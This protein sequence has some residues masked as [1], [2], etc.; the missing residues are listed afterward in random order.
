MELENLLKKLFEKIIE[1]YNLGISI[2]SE[3]EVVLFCDK[4]ILSFLLHSAELEMV[5]I[6]KRE[7]EELYQY[8]ID[9]FITYSISDED[10]LR[11][12]SFLIN[13]SKLEL[14]LGLL[15]YTLEKK[16][17]ELLLGGNRW[18]QE[19]ENFMLYIPARNVTRLKEKS[20]KGKCL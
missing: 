14:E 18:I 4:Y 2:I 5:Y 6:E 16:W 17:G 11:I 19:Y 3:N 9:S 13:G 7:N 12:K 20:Y 15:A 10:R 1:T 8:N